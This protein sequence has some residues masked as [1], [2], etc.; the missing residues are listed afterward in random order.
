MIK[1][2][3]EQRGNVVLLTKMMTVKYDKKKNTLRARGLE[4]ECVG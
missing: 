1:Q 2:D 3:K 4:N